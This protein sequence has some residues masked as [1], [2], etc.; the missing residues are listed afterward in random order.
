MKCKCNFD[1]KKCNAN[2]IWNNDKYRWVQKL[3]KKLCWKGH[4]WNPATCSF[5]NCRYVGS[6]IYDSVIPCDEIIKITKKTLL[7][8]KV[9]Q[10]ILA[11]KVICKMKSFYILLAFLLITIIYSCF[12]KYQTKC[13]HLSPFYN[14]SEKKIDIKNI[15]KSGKYLIKRNSY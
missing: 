15:L 7:Q 3:K 10:Q 6:N 12:I 5:E 1:G 2:Q 13:K 8:L 9:F 11:K 4:L 14:A